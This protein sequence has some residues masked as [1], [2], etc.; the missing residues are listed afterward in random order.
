M[1]VRGERGTFHN[2]N[3]PSIVMPGLINLIYARC[4]HPSIAQILNN[5]LCVRTD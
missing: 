4:V 2:K 3:S 5:L 1:T